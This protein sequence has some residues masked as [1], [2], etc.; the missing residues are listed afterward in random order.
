MTNE[1]KVPA[2]TSVFIATPAYHGEVKARYALSLLWTTH[3][4]T[5]SGIR[6]KPS[7]FGGMSAIQIARNVQVAQFMAGA[8]SHLLFIDGDLGW[9]PEAVTR[10]LAASQCEDCGVVTG[11]YPKR[12]HPLSWPVN[13]ASQDGEPIIHPETGYIELRD[14][15]TGFMLIRRDVI[16][17]MMA[18]YP[19]RQC[20]F[21]EDQDTPTDEAPYEFLLFDFYIDPSNRRYLSE[22]FGFCRLWQALGGH[23]WADPEIEL[24]HDGYTGSI[25]SLFTG[26]P[27]KAKAA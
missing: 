12:C 10:L 13:F 2:D 7:C 4:L 21:R 9:K 22:D 15:T 17:K 18:A 6:H 25:R 24:N 1:I 11:V 8:W 23:V 16:V 5:E 19:E 20:S 3:V 27:E 26:L 14:A